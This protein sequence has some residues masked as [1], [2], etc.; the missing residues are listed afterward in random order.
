MRVIG[1]VSQ[2]YLKGPPGVEHTTSGTITKTNETC[3]PT[4]GLG[5]SQ[6][7]D[8]DLDEGDYRMGQLP[9]RAIDRYSNHLRQAH[10]YP[11]AGAEV[12]KR[13]LTMNRFAS[14]RGQHERQ[15]YRYLYDF[16]KLY[17]VGKGA[18]P[19]SALST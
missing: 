7:D 16:P 13:C 1:E 17:L 18:K 6:L 4:I 14:H 15:G 8:A 12:E 10:G 11:K 5:L 3:L 9:G 2:S 19:R